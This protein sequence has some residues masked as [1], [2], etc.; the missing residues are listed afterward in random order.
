MSQRSHNNTPRV[1]LGPFDSLD[2]DEPEEEEESPEQEE[3][4][5]WNQVADVEGSFDQDRH[6]DRI[7]EDLCDER[8]L[9]GE[10]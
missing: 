9:G 3:E 10:V 2:D 4:R 7:P 6:R 1:P 8:E 5:L